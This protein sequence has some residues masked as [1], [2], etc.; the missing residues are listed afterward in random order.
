[1]LGIMSLSGK[2]LIQITTRYACAGIVINSKGICV[3]AAPIYKWMLDK[4]I[5]TIIEWKRITGY[6]PVSKF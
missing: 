5:R 4:H 6:K 2:L 1:M 3:E